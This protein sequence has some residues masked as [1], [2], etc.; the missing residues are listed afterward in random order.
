MIKVNCNVPLGS[1]L[2]PYQPLRHHILDVLGGL[3]SGAFGLAGQAAQASYTKE[4]QKLQSKLN[5][6]EMATSQGMQNAQHQE[7]M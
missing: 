2:N 5:K 4:Q 1:G 7:K 3:I 6:E